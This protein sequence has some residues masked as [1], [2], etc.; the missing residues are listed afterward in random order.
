MNIIWQGIDNLSGVKYVEIQYKVNSGG[1]WQTLATGSGM[2]WASLSVDPHNIY[3]FRARAQD[4]AGNWSS[5]SVEI[6]I[7]ANILYL[8]ILVR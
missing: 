5:Y 3:Y 6:P 1:G 4:E 8:P 2:G 7:A